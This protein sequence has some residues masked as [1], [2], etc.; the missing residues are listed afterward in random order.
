M[1]IPACG[2]VIPACGMVIPTCGMVIPTC[3]MVIPATE[4]TGVFAANSHTV[5]K[6]N[7]AIN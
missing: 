5:M 2:M 6:N 1:V 4:A 3:G 7:A